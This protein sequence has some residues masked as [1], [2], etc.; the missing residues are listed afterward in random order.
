MVDLELNLA[1]LVLC[2]AVVDACLI[3]KGFSPT[4]IASNRIYLAGTANDGSR[5]TN[6]LLVGLH[7]GRTGDMDGQMAKWR[8]QVPPDES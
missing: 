1:Q 5:A 8:L 2:G 4:C 6:P 7:S 3:S